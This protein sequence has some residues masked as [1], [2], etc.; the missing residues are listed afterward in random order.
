MW[1]CKCAVFMALS[2]IFVFIHTVKEYTCT[3]STS[4]TFK[5]VKAIQLKPDVRDNAALHHI[6]T[7]SI[8]L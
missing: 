3:G 5:L 8:V 1:Q 4:S 2:D 7:F 6:P